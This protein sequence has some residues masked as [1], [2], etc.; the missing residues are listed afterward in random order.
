MKLTKKQRAQKAVREIRAELKK[1]FGK[2]FV[3]FSIENSKSG[4]LGFFALA[5]L[6]LHGIPARRGTTVYQ[7][8][9][10]IEVPKRYERRAGKLIL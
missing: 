1:E 10:G 8:H 4:G 6:K 3:T 7:D 5:I 9:V 2:G